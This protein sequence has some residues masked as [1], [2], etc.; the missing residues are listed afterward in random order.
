MQNRSGCQSPVALFSLPLLVVLALSAMTCGAARAQGTSVNIKKDA[1]EQ[2]DWH[3]GRRHIYIT[4]ET[5]RVTDLRRGQ[6]KT[7]YTISIPPAPDGSVTRM[8]LTL[9][10]GGNGLTPAGF[11]SQISPKTPL[12]LP[13]AKMGGHAPIDRA[14]P[15]AKARPVGLPASRAVMGKPATTAASPV[16]AMTP[17]SYSPYQG[18]GA[19]GNSSGASVQTKAELRGRLLK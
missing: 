16:R 17:S 9:T 4:D 7:E 12:N 1:L 15:A 2:V 18:S 8:P 11:A 13:A 5:P 6:N 14:A 19:S 3:H 10:P